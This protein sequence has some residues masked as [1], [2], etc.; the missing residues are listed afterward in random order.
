MFKDK[1]RKLLKNENLT[2]QDIAER[3]GKSP[4]TLYNTF[5]YEGK[6]IDG[7]KYDGK[8]RSLNYSTAEELLEAAGYEIV[9]R[10]K[11]GSEIIC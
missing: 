4:Q 8:T 11:D 6:Q 7:G 9:F 1:F 10:K 5:A 3:I 2:M